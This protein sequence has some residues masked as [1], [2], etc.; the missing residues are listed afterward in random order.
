[1]ANNIISGPNALVAKVDVADINTMPLSAE[2]TTRLYEVDG[3]FR[4][5]SPTSTINPVTSLVKNRGYLLMAKQGMDLSQYFA[6][7]LPTGGGG[8][9]GVT[10]FVTV[11][12]PSD[13]PGGTNNTTLS[14]TVTPA[15]GHTISQLRWVAISWPSG[16]AAPTFASPNAT[17]TVVN[18]LHTGTFII[19]FQATD[20]AGNIGVG[21]I[22]F[23]VQVSNAIQVNAGAA[24]ELDEGVSTTNLY[25]TI[26]VSGIAV[27]DFVEWSVVT[28][29]VT[30]VAFSTPDNKDTGVT[31]IPVATG[32]TG[33][34]PVTFRLTAYDTDG[35]Q[36]HGDVV[37]TSLKPST[38]TATTGW[39]PDRTTQG[40]WVYLPQGYDPARAQGYPFIL[41]LHGMG[42][43][44]DGELEGEPNNDDINVLLRESAGMPYFIYNKLYAMKSVV[45]A[46][47]LH[48]GV[49][50]ITQAQK[51]LDYA[52]DNYNLDQTYIGV[53]GLSSGGKGA[54][55]LCVANPST[56]S[57]SIPI[58]PIYS[59][60]GTGQGAVVKDI[61]FTIVTSYGDETGAPP[62]A[63]GNA[64]D[65]IDSICAASPKGLFPPRVICV[66]DTGHEPQTWNWQVYDKRR[67]IFDFENDFF[68]LHNKNYATTCT[69]YVARAEKSKTFYDWSLAMVQVDKMAAGTAKSQLQ[70]RL[71]SVLTT[72]TSGRGH[73]YIMLNLGSTATNPYYSINNAPS[74]TPGAGITGMINTRG[75]AKGFT[76]TVNTNTDTTPGNDAIDHNEMG[77][78]AEMFKSYFTVG[79]SN[80]TLGGLNTGKVY[81][82][83]VYCS[84]RSESLKGT[85]QRTGC[86]ISFNNNWTQLNFEGWNTMFTAQ[87]YGV[88]PDVSGNIVITA[89]N[90]WT[91]YGVVNAILIRERSPQDNRLKTGRFNWAKTN[92][93]VDPLE[94]A[95]IFTDP[96]VGT[97]SAID[98]KSG[99]RIE[100]IGTGVPYWD[101]AYDTYWADD[102]VMTGVSTGGFTPMRNV[103]EVVARSGWFN[104][105]LY[106]NDDTPN[107]NIRCVGVPGMGLPAGLYQ[108]RMYCAS[109]NSEAS[110]TEFTAKFTSGGIQ[111]L[112][113]TTLNNFSGKYVTF[114]GRVKEGDYINFG[115]FMPNFFGFAF[116]NYLEIEKV[117]D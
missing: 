54:L 82:F 111:S 50:D 59:E 75:Q 4:S 42:E 102:N 20:D 49:W 9:G 100:T 23:I 73:D 87:V 113:T 17:E 91:S 83:Y 44:G 64:F 71:S 11:S 16:F 39:D 36:Y 88:S 114:T 55:D 51:A 69:N 7:L 10:P 90:L 72:I 13:L 74:S 109:T 57:A 43:N 53:T 81:D 106:F 6:P 104:E 77:M 107:Y 62:S 63:A 117:E 76:F 89:N 41:F 52:Q 33:N 35:N 79:G 19:Q 65:A 103:P 3:A 96:T 38:M 46:P 115:L 21:Q 31:G 95:T 85:G 108:A 14:A 80:W 45:L 116:L 58:C 30:T 24:Q 47:Q 67:A 110:S 12:G 66:W 97:A 60:V 78:S 40:M 70:V 48:T 61:P 26:T 15:E 101:K 56:F 93:G 86:E 94:F 68:L 1:M 25:G 112:R 37:V 5:W 22:T 18:G 92:S 29:G 28:P 105:A 32:I 98:P 34:L 84:D 27:L 99:W 8:G 2:N